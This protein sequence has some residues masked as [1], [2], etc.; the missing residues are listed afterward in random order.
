MELTPD[1]IATAH[2]S[3]TGNEGW[4]G[5]LTTQEADRWDTNRVVDEEAQTFSF[6]AGKWWWTISFRELEAFLDE[7]QPNWRSKNYIYAHLPTRLGTFRPY[8]RIHRERLAEQRA[9]LEAGATKWEAVPYV[10]L[11]C[12]YNWA[13]EID[14]EGYEILTGSQWAAT[15]REALACRA[16]PITTSVG[17]NEELEIEDEFT[18]L[19]YFEATEMDATD[20]ETLIRLK[21][22]RKGNS[23]DLCF[24][25]Y[26]SDEHPTPYS[27][28]PYFD[29]HDPYFARFEQQHW[30]SLVERDE[31]YAAAYPARVTDTNRAMTLAR[32]KKA[33]ALNDEVAQELREVT[34][35]D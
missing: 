13:D 22:D 6:R 29:D 9:E 25:N 23:L 15:I 2:F 32:R 20:A 31:Q 28:G 33:D 18:Y 21:M 14:F 19:G 10:K 7:T 11:E 3:Y 27:S 34:I 1:V 30:L 16:W 24:G 26:P 4:D 8:Y 35:E 17:S 12:S 5:K